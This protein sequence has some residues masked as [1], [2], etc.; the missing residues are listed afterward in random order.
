[1]Q[2]LYPG[3]IG[4]LEI[5]VGFSGG[6]KIGEPGEKCENQQQTQLTDDIRWE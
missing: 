5:N 2:V 4:I 6:R 3:R 1:M